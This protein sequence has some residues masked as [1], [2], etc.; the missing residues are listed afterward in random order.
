MGNHQGYG[1]NNFH[2]PEQVI[3]AIEQ[4]PS[5]KCHTDFMFWELPLI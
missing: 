3:S 1:D 5:L 2:D 4:N